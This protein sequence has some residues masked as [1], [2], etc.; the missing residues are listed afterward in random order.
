[1][2]ES[3]MR[4][5]GMTQTWKGDDDDDSNR[6]VNLTDHPAPDDADEEPVEIGGYNP[7][8]GGDNGEDNNREHR[9]PWNIP[10]TTCVFTWAVVYGTR[11]CWRP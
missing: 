3:L 9:A 8:V 5:A 1:M 7:N 2:R 4:L 6:V 11:P 10:T